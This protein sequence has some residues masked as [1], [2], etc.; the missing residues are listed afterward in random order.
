M[1]KPGSAKDLTFIVLAMKARVVKNTVR[2]GAMAQGL[3]ALAALP[4]DPERETASVFPHGCP[5]LELLM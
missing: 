1:A 2:T 5:F 3:R 4:E